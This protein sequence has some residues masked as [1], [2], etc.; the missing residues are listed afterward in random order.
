MMILDMLRDVTTAEILRSLN[1]LNGILII[2]SN[3]LLYTKLRK[4]QK[5][6]QRYI[7][8]IFQIF[9]YTEKFSLK[10]CLNNSETLNST[11]LD[12]EYFHTSTLLEA[13]A[14]IPIWTVV[15]EP[16]RARDTTVS[17]SR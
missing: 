12:N 3:I 14:I 9:H 17:E 8:G 10:N 5:L 15:L 6:T 13:Y 11:L 2:Y 4:L 7:Q 1:S 16:L